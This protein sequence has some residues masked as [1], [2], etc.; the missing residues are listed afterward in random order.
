M[1]SRR[2]AHGF[3]QFVQDAQLLM[4]ADLLGVIEASLAVRAPGMLGWGCDPEMRGAP[5]LRA[6]HR[7]HKGNPSG[8]PLLHLK[9]PKPGHFGSNIVVIRDKWLSFGVGTF[10][11]GL[12]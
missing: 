1:V 8:K 3:H 12:V 5:F 9:R 11:F 4:G 10:L 2:R 6:N 7:E